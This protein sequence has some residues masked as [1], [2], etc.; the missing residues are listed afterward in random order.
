MPL[1]DR[2][3]QKIFGKVNINIFI[4]L[5][6]IVSSPVLFYTLYN[7]KLPSSQ[8]GR[9]LSTYSQF[10]A[11]FTLACRVRVVLIRL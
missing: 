10:E 11:I 5:W 8:N 6:K 3:E 4:F 2:V 1:A 9:L 7:L